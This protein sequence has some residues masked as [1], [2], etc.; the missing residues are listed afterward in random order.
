MQDKITG[1]E[2]TGIELNIFGISRVKNCSKNLFADTLKIARKLKPG[3]RFVINLILV[4]N[5]EIRALKRVY[6]KKNINTD[7]ISFA[8]NQKKPDGSKILEGDIY[9]SFEQIEVQAPGFGNSFYKELLYVITHGILHVLGYADYTRKE[10][11][12]MFA[13]QDRVFNGLFKNKKW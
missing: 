10:R 11:L 5:S 4:D 1:C 6:H 3:C 9:V 2:G 12:R 8:Y 7:V 13:E